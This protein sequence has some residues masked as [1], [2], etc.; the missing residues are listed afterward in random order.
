M[1]YPHPQLSQ[2]VASLS[3]SHF[4]ILPISF[5]LKCILHSWCKLLKDG[6]LWKKSR[7]NGRIRR[8]QRWIDIAHCIK[9]H[10]NCERRVSRLH[11][12]LEESNE[13]AASSMPAAL[14]WCLPFLA[15]ASQVHPSA[16]LFIVSKATCMFGPSSNTCLFRWKLVFSQ[17]EFPLASALSSC[18]TPLFLIRGRMLR[19]SCF[20]SNALDKQWFDYMKKC[21]EWSGT[22]PEKGL[23]S[24]K[25]A[26]S[27][28]R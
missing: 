4:G 21:L 9:V 1:L 16:F 15:P 3:A 2:S 24:F 28:A 8:S 13:G 25:N 26:I 14:L 6:G 23:D 10:V 20:C 11:S 19:P 17:K 5:S 7:G 27:A 22:W 18:P 12:A